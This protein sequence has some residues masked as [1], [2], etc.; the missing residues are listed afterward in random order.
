MDEIYP[1]GTALGDVPEA[2]KA[3]FDLPCLIGGIGTCCGLRGLLARG[4]AAEAAKKSCAE[5]VEGLQQRLQKMQQELAKKESDQ[6]KKGADKA[7][8]EAAKAEK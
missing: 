4:L 5:Q 6:G 1:E 3:L 7:E 8:K 2:T